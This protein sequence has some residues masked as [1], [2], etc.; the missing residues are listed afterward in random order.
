MKF[1][2]ASMKSFTSCEI[3]SSNPLQRAYSGFLIAACA[4]KSQN[5]PVILKIVLKASYEHY[6][7]LTNGAKTSY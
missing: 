1:L 3:P 7:K 6:K 5:P 4:F 2:L